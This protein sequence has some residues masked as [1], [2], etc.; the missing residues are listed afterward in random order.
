MGHELMGTNSP[1]D[2]KIITIEGSDGQGIAM[3]YRPKKEL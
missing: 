3:F 2:F 1:L